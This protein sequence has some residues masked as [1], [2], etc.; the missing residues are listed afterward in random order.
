MN[1]QKRPIKLGAP[2]LGKKEREALCEVLA[3][4]W[5]TMGPRVAQ[6][7][8]AFAEM[9]GAAHG[10]AVNSGTASLHLA[11]KASGIGPGDEVLVP[12]MTFAATVNAVLYCGATPVPV[13]IISIHEPHLCLKDA[14]AALSKQTR[15]VIIMHYGGYIMNVPK[16]KEFCD[17]R[18]LLLIEDAAHAPLG[19]GVGT[20]SHCSVFSFYTNKNMTTS[21]GGMVLTADEGLSNRMKRM[22]SHGITKSTLQRD[23]GQA[24]FYDIV[25]L[26]YNYRM[27]ELQATMGQTQLEQLPRWNM[28][29]IELTTHY[30]SLLHGSVVK[31]IFELEHPTSAHL[32][33]VLLPKKTH[34]G[35]VMARLR[36]EGIQSSIHYLPVHLF[37]YHRTVL[38]KRPLPHTEA[39]ADRELTLP[40]HPQ[41][42][43]KDVDFTCKTLLSILTSLNRKTQ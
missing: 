42:S 6:F 18:D 23:Q 7:E 25:E 4:G 31:L 19:P 1:P 21:E 16:W 5:I 41:L 34:R 38:P 13:D 12:S 9:H 3:S 28:R 43:K 2:T 10:V 14:Q 30:R 27:N 11:L 24:F 20:C 40:L 33:P 35:K 15:A 37:S 8:K 36:E 22:R 26:G 29:R 17:E 39:F 32:L